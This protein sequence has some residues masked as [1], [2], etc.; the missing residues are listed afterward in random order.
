MENQR[1][2]WNK[3]TACLH[4][5]SKPT[6]R[7]AHLHHHISLY[8]FWPYKQIAAIFL[9]MH[10]RSRAGIGKDSTSHGL[11][12]VIFLYEP[13]SQ[14]IGLFFLAFCYLTGL[15]LSN[16][17]CTLKCLSNKY[18]STVFWLVQTLYRACLSCWGLTLLSVCLKCIAD[19]DLREGGQI[20][21][22][23]QSTLE[24]I[25]SPHFLGSPVMSTR[26]TL[27]C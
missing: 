17:M 12:T 4:P 25:A 16:D 2:S 27:M 3:R 10:W 6:C 14:Y 15:F 18:L 26:S 7:A 23:P 19:T 22:A 13:L 20:L 21:L 8:H 11:W 1:F 5:L 9:P 24:R